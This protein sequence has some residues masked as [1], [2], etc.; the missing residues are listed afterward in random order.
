TIARLIGEPINVQL[1]VPVELAK[2]ADVFTAEPGEKVWR[3]TAFDSSLDTV[4][5]VDANGV[6]TQVKRTP[7]GDAELTFSGLNS[8]EEYVLIDDIL[9]ETDNTSVLARR[10]ESISRAMDK[11]E[12]RAII[13]AILANTA[14]FLPGV[15]CPE[16]VVSSTHDLYDVI[17]GMK[18][19][20]EDYGTDYVLLCG[21]TVKEKID[22][23]DKD[24]VGSFNY[25]IALIDRIAKLGIEVVKVFGKVEI[26]N[27]GGE[28]ALMDSKKLILV[29]KNSRI[30]EGKP[31]KFV[32]RKIGSAIA[33]LMG[34]DVDKAQRALIIGQTPVNKAGVNTLAYSVYGYES[35][36]FTITNPKAISIADAT[37]IL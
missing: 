20:V 34:A 37:V 25:N 17:M 27:G 10:K 33:K 19:L 12:V 35:N 6:I 13:T 9:S 1:P 36:I 14:G 3:Y 7:I 23:Y 32:R 28:L 4:L 8:K 24:N 29:A 16:F 26:T 11:K 15:D 5:A 30:A 18:H 22:T 2:I 31:I 21:T